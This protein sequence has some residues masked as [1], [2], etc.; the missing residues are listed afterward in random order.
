MLAVPPAVLDLLHLRAGSRV[1]L[2][3]DGQRLVID[4]A[5]KPHY[6][7]DE[8]LEQCD[9]NAPIAEEDRSWLDLPSVGRE[10]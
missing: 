3:V 6:T 8:L 7:L 1:G 2:S 9:S 4:P 10:L 5:V